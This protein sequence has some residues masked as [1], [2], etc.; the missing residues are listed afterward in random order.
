MEAIL[1]DLL[2]WDL[3]EPNAW[4]GPARVE[5]GVVPGVVLLLR[6]SLAL[7]I[8]PPAIES[9]RRPL[10]LVSQGLRPE[11]DQSLGIGAVNR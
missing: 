6:K 7:P 1:D 10:Y 8:G 2:L 5:Y 11:T 3:V 4:P 9:S